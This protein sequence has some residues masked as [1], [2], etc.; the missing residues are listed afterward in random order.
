MDDLV[1]DDVDDGLAN[2]I[3]GSGKFTH[4][5][6]GGK[7]IIGKGRR[8]NCEEDQEKCGDYGACQCRGSEGNGPRLKSGPHEKNSFL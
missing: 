7:R 1:A 5:T 8:E 4:K 3:D 6:R 2:F